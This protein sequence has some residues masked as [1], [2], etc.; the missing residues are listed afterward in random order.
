M[1]LSINQC[2]LENKRM[3]IHDNTQ[4]EALAMVVAGISMQ[5]SNTRLC[6]LAPLM[7]LDRS[8]RLMVGFAWLLCYAVWL[9]VWPSSYFAGCSIDRSNARTMAGVHIIVLPPHMSNLVLLAIV[10][11]VGAWECRGMA[12]A[13]AWSLAS[14]SVEAE[15][16]VE[17]R[18]GGPTWGLGQADGQEAAVDVGRSQEQTRAIESHD[19]KQPIKQVRESDF[20]HNTYQWFMRNFAQLLHK[21]RH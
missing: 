8:V 4:R 14:S 15:A 16:E 9:L 18:D 2:S 21:S 5:A 19:G 11:F 20:E 17:A 1:D 10:A 13:A 6:T 3:L 12:L 7:L